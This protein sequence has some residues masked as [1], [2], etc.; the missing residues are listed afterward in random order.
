MSLMVQLVGVGLSSSA[1]TIPTY[2]G[3]ANTGVGTAPAYSGVRFGSDG[4]VYR[5]TGT[6]AVQRIGTWLLSGS[7]ASYY[8]QTTDNGPDALTQD[9]GDGV[10]LNANRDYYVT[11]STAVA[12]GSTCSVTYEISTDAPGSTVV[13]GPKTYYFEADYEFD[14]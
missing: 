12:G 3:F 5:F 11:D 6:G 9:A 8:L 7:A 1:V 4:D 2:S 13:A 10:Q 14:A